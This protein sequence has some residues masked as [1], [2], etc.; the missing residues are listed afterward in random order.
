MIKTSRVKFYK[1]ALKQIDK[2]TQ[3]ALEKS[4]EYL[5][6]E[7]VQAQ[8]V[9][10]KDNI[11]QGT[12]FYADYSGSEKGSVSLVHNTPYARRLYFHPEYNFKTEPWQD[13]DGT[14]EGNPNARGL[15]FEPWQPGGEHEGDFKKAFK[16]FL[17][18]PTGGAGA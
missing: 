17:N 6:T 11:L 2:A 15:W 18:M 9:P 16:H 3:T 4:A 12:A 7:I 13:A 1:G 5:H 8:V 14:H 10:R